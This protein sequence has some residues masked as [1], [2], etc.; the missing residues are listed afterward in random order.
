[1]VG[2]VGRLILVQ[3]GVSSAAGWRLTY[4]GETQY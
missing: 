2:T 1:M 3:P 4:F